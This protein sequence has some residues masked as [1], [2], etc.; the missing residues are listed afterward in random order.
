MYLRQ[1]HFVPLLIVGGLLAIALNLPGGIAE[2]VKSV[3]RESAA[4]LQELIRMVSVRLREGIS[5]VRG[6][7]GLAAENR[8]MARELVR[9]RV[10]ERRLEALERENL[11]LRALLKFESKD[12]RKLIPCEVIARDASG[13]WQ[14]IRLNKGTAAGV[15]KDC[16]VITPD[17]L[18]GR[19]VAASRNTAEVLL[20]SDPACRVSARIPRS[21][22]AGI[23][24]GAGVSERGQVLCLMKF[25]TK[26][27]PAFPGD[28]VVTSG[29]GGVFP[30]GLLIGYVER[31]H[32]GRNGLYQEAEIVPRADL[33]ALRYVFV[34]VGDNADAERRGGAAAGPQGGGDRR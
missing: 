15:E 28:E 12:S 32:L 4:P 29:L 11:E 21:D 13:W 26:E 25:I 30:A 7:G 19:T 8:E 10:R 23:T 1:R 22:A 5:V 31:V 34:V 33:A 14:T 16:A 9:L 6:I 2:A 24:V 18:V 20:I 27:K 3:V 17:G